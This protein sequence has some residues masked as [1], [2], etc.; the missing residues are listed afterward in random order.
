MARSCEAGALAPSERPNPSLKGLIDGALMRSRF[1]AIERGGD[2]QL[3]GRAA[4]K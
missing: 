4:A 3:N 1:R 2:V